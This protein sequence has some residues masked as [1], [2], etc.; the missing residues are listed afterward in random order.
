MYGK[1][2]VWDN[3]FITTTSVYDEYCEFI[4]GVMKKYDRTL[5]ERNEQREPRVDGFLTEHL[6]LIW[7]NWKFSRKDIDH[8]EVRNI[9]QDEFEDYKNTIKGKCIRWAHRNHSILSLIR[10][11]RIG[12]LLIKRKDRDV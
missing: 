2:T 10:Y 12:W 6:L 5:L 7:F 8:M 1:F 11:T 3:M 9:E 4:F